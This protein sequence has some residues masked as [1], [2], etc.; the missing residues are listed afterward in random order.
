MSLIFD[1][2]N[3]S[4]EITETD[5]PYYITF[6]FVRFEA[7]HLGEGSDF[8]KENIASIFKTNC[9]LSESY[10]LPP[11]SCSTYSSNM[12]VELCSTET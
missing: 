2:L 7:I 9:K 10:G 5:D 6:L 1:G 3:K 4:G 12:L 11:A 8:S